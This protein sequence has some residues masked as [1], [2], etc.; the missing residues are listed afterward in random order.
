MMPVSAADPTAGEGRFEPGRFEPGRFEL[1]G[2]A[3]C[4]DFANTWGDRRRPES[5]R[6]DGYPALLAFAG[7]A[8]LLDRRRTARLA[9]HA[10]AAAAEAARAYASARALREALYRVFSAQA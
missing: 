3:L 7:E 2:G 8:G 6:L 1:T 5:D 10:R 9:R 4:L